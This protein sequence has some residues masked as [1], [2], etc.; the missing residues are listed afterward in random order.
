MRKYERIAENLYDLEEKSYKVWR[1]QLT[2]MRDM[3]SQEYKE[4]EVRKAELK[5]LILH[6]L[7]LFKNCIKWYRQRAKTVEDF[8][9]IVDLE[10]EYDTFYNHFNCELSDE[11]LEQEAI[12][13]VNDLLSGI[14]EQEKDEETTEFT[15][16]LLS[17]FK[18]QEEADTQESSTKEKTKDSQEIKEPVE[19]RLRL[20]YHKQNDLM[21]IGI[22]DNSNSYADQDYGSFVIF[23]DDDTD[24]ITGY[25]IFGFLHKYENNTLPLI[26]EPVKIDYEKDIMPFFQME[27]SF[28]KI[29]DVAEKIKEVKQ[30]EMLN[31]DTN[32]CLPSPHSF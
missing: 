16:K 14:E 11:E 23:K 32:F 20:N 15:K 4:L 24:E 19:N 18:K 28:E 30:Q 9:L 31:S 3:D 10:E 22:G 21:Y 8:E 17:E 7:E 5:I 27:S 1:K 2:L 25:Y 6:E 26:T 12:G 29:K 13:V